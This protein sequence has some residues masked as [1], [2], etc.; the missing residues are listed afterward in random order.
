MDHEQQIYPINDQSS[1][2]YR[3]QPI[4]LLSK[5]ID[6]FLYDGKHWSLIG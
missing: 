2:K 5:S 4:T 3:N 1:R 6:W